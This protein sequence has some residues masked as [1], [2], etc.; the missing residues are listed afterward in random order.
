MED[1]RHEPHAVDVEQSLL[2]SCL[3]DKRLIDQAAALIEPESF[4]D[5]LHS[6][7]FEAMVHLAATGNVTPLILNAALKS[8][9][10]LR[11]LGG[12]SYLAG[13]AAAAPALPNLKEHVNILLDLAAKRK[14]IAIGEQIISDA[15]ESPREKT[16]VIIVSEH[17]DAMLR[18]G[19]ARQ[20]GPKR[21][22]AVVRESVQAA[23]NHLQHGSP[24]KFITTGSIKMDKAIGGMQPGD[25]I[26][27]AARTGMG[28]SLQASA[29]TNAAARGGAP[30][31]IVSADMKAKQWADR[32][33]C[34]VDLMLNPGIK[35][36]YYSK[37]RN[38]TLSNEEI[39]RLMMAQRTM[40]EW[41]VEIDDNPVVSI[42]ALRGRVRS[43]ARRFPN[44]QGLL[45]V[46]FLQ[47]VEPPKGDRRRDEDLT[48]ISYALGD[49]VR[50]IGWSLLALIQ[51]KN[52]DTD[53]KGNLREDPPSVA[54]I[55]ESGGIEQAMDIL[56]GPYRKAFFIERREPDG[57]NHAGGPPP[58]WLSWRGE[59]REYEN[60][61]RNIGYKNR[62]GRASALNIDLWCNPGCAAVRDEDP[63]PRTTLEH[64]PQERLEF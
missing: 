32:A 25:R 40:E 28:K 47:K 46:D 33:A 61:L 37:F 8:D 29:I 42:P 45:V 31:F 56:F 36:I 9:P 34:D 21:L 26:G 1:I 2:G 53:G 60:R 59:L 15:H 48:F 39:A 22:S 55:R 11:E 3:I 4:Y 44:Q 54:D 6:R 23:E 30:I 5:P 7:L 43:M 27:L 16:A 64:D 57:R 17:T 24:I 51:M 52:K 20:G 13:L 63:A 62:D 50:D 38:G 18:I 35:P 19:E 58:D 49:I 12:A 14:L 10:G 41:N